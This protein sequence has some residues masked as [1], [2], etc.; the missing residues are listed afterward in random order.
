[1]TGSSANFGGARRRQGF[2]AERALLT[3]VGA[4]T[5]Y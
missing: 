1:M 5:E 4:V 2:L 3:D